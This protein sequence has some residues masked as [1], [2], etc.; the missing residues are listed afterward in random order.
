MYNRKKVI[1]ASVSMVLAASLS[2]GGTLAAPASALAA[3][4]S[5]SSSS[6][7]AANSL[8]VADMPAELKSSIEWVW[9]N[10]MAPA[11]VKSFKNLIYD[12]IFAGKGTLNYVVQ[13]QSSKKITLQQRKDM[14]SMLQRQLN[15]WTKH[16]QGYDGWPYGDIQVKIVGW[17]VSDAS[18]IVD[19]QS[20]EIVYTDY[21]IDELSASNPRIPAKLPVAPDALS[22]F[23]HYGDPNYSYPGGLSKRF[24]MYLWGTTNFEG[25]A[26]GDWG[27]RMSDDYILSVLNSNESVIV[28]HEMGHGFGLPDFYEDADRPPGGFP[29]STIMWAGN[30]QTISNWDIWMFRYTWSQLKKDTSRFPAA[31]SDSTNVN[32]KALKAKVTSSYCSPW[33]NV[34]ALNDGFDPAHSNDRSH[35]VYGNWPQT[36]TQ[37][38]QYDFDQS[39]TISQ[40]DVYW[41]KD[42]Q[43][44]D[45]PKS[46]KIKYW[47]GKTWVDVKNASG[48]GTGTNKYNPT[49]FTPVHTKSIRV[50]MTP[51]S[52]MSTGILELK[53]K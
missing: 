49:T 41:F 34:S 11:G 4:G 25:G 20:N 35:A 5:Y 27:Q 23:K 22:R 21:V 36:G 15:N 9:N 42:N 48:L 26:G 13:W 10:R 31:G 44:I 39:F 14:A 43:G 30:S 2:I 50:E 7:A 37:W 29:T 51:K 38:V 1:A 24:D 33:E 28:E 17:A 52:S 32:N 46:Y 19:K 3:A 53:V 18:Q 6:L 47:D 8:S 40:T 12:Q 45:V 16:L